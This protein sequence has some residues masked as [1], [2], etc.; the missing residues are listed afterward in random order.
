MNMGAVGRKRTV[1]GKCSRRG[2]HGKC[3]TSWVEVGGWVDTL[4]SSSSGW[5]ACWLGFW[6]EIGKTLAVS[7]GLEKIGFCVY[8]V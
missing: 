4:K 1:S 7:N 2:C 6:N 8:W 3:G 5:I